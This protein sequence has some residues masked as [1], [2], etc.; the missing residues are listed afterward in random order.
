ME[1]MVDENASNLGGLAAPLSAVTADTAAPLARW[2]GC[3]ASRRPAD[4]SHFSAA[5]AAAEEHV[6]AVGLEARHGHAERHVQLF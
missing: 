3:G 5:S 2:F 6:A 4:G 1:G